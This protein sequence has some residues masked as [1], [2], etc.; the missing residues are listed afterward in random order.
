MRKKVLWIEDSAFDEIAVLAVPVHLSGEYEL[1]FA[2][3]ATEGA[4]RLQ[5]A[6]PEYDAVVVDIR[7]PPGE[8]P[9]WI[10]EYISLQRAR[11]PSRLGLT[12][13]E[14]T[15]GEGRRDWAKPFPE[16]ARQRQRY[17]VLTVESEAEVGPSLKRLRVRYRSKGSGDDTDVLLRLIEDILADSR[18]T[19]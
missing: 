17:G 18:V 5:H 2:L 9:W 10:N 15:V 4:A 12:L 1:D 6:A 8:D 14:L 3:S 16:W 13:L 7:L 11:K 19:E